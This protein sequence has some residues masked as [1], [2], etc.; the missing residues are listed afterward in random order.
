VDDVGAD[1]V[2]EGLVV[3]DDEKSLLPVLQVVV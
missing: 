3:G 2:E 1:I